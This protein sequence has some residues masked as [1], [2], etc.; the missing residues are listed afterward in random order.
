M[1]ACPRPQIS[2]EGITNISLD[3]TSLYGLLWCQV[4]LNAAECKLDNF[5]LTWPFHRRDLSPICTRFPRPV[6]AR[7]FVASVALAL[8]TTHWTHD[9]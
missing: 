6:S 1:L 7:S 3:I 2:E 9:G 5:I 8:P 4:C